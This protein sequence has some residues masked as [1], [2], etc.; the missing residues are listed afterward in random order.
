MSQLEACRLASD[1][2]TV[3]QAHGFDLF[4][5]IVWISLAV[6]ICKEVVRLYCVYTLSRDGIT[7]NS[8][9]AASEQPCRR[10]TAYYHTRL[11]LCR[12][13]MFVPLLYFSP[14]VT[15]R[16][17]EMHVVSVNLTW[18]DRLADL[19]VDGVLGSFMQL[20]VAL[21]FA[22][23]VSST[24]LDIWSWLSIPSTLVS[25]I[26]LLAITYHDWH[27]EKTGSSFSTS[28]KRHLLHSVDVLSDSSR[29]GVSS[30]GRLGCK[31]G[32][33]VDIN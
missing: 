3:K 2:L 16:L 19:W 29:V 30:E 5:L 18:K 27:K 26:S 20:G 33:T 1:G 22:L 31:V 28:Q 12:H 14:R 15:P 23:F 6:L 17:F 11:V 10:H 13:S 9:P 4:F 24:N 25:A 21:Y 8:D 32:R 7:L